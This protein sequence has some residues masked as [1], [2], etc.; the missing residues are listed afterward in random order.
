[1][2]EFVAAG[3]TLV[4]AP[5]AVFWGGYSSYVADLDGHLWEIAHNPYLPM[6]DHGRPV[7]PD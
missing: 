2:A 7:L 4:K 6:D 1:V 3:A 5:Q